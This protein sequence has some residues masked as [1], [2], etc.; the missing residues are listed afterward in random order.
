VAGHRDRSEELDLWAAEEDGERQGVADVGTE[1]R[2]DHER[3]P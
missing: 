3:T 1:V 2:V